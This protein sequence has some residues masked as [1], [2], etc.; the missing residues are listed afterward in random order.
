M[1]TQEVKFSIRSLGTVRMFILMILWS[2][3][4]LGHGCR[5]KN[6]VF[7]SNH[8]L[9]CKHHKKDI[10]FLNY[11]ELIGMYHE[12]LE[13][14]L[15]TRVRNQVTENCNFIIGL[16]L[17]S[18]SSLTLADLYLVLLTYFVF[19]AAWMKFGLHYTVLHDD[20]SLK[21]R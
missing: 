2:S 13:V 15:E 4:N 17:I 5:V 7:M 14:K 16:V 21:L 19:E 18:S 3:I 20:F 6:Q 8:R 9:I 12:Y 11:L 10:F 1:F